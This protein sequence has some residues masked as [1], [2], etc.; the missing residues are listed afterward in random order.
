[1]QAGRAGVVGAAALAAGAAG[2]AALGKRRRQRGWG[3]R[4]RGCL[5]KRLARPGDGYSWEE[6]GRH[7][8]EIKVYVPIGD[9]VNYRDVAFELAPGGRLTVGIQGCTPVIDGEALWGSVDTEDSEW[10]VEQHE[11]QRSIV[12]LLTKRNVRE[13]WE[14]LLKKDGAFIGPQPDLVN[15]SQD[16]AV[17][18]QMD[19]VQYL[20]QQ[21]RLEEAQEVLR[22]MTAGHVEVTDG[23][24]VPVKTVDRGRGWRAA[25]D[26]SA[27]EVLLY[28][29]AFCYSECGPDRFNIMGQQC[30]TKSDDPFF[31]GEVLSLSTAKGGETG[32]LGILQ[33]NT[34][35]CSR[36]PGWTALFAS[37]A[38]FNHSCCPNAFLDSSKSTG[39]VR[40][41][42]QIPVG[43]EVCLS[44]VLVSDTLESRR[45]NLRPFGFECSCDRCREEESSDPKFA[46]PCACGHGK[47]PFRTESKANNMQECHACGQRFNCADAHRV[48]R[49]MEA[50]CDYMESAEAGRAESA[51]LVKMLEPLAAEAHPSIFTG[52][53]DSVATEAL[54]APPRHPVVIR[55][56]DH[57]ARCHY[58]VAA[59]SGP[60]SARDRA[61]S[62]YWECRRRALEGHEANHGSGAAQRDVSYLRRLYQ[63]LVDGLPEEDRETWR[64]KLPALCQV[65]F[66]EAQMPKQLVE[67]LRPFEL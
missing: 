57:L 53:S 41:L 9:E 26:I 61:F 25:K 8:H 52:S 34:F 30:M 40:A 14:H 66:G 38:R 2:A 31:K 24:I 63:L 51:D 55:L 18:E 1:M 27:G 33:N 44:Y 45:A 56:L 20:L 49:E 6:D 19:Y 21:H 39:I 50:M 42:R 22:N 47:S 58:A 67:D 54:Q 13:S 23:R 62:A 3:C 60:G 32:L 15:T 12:V 17:L 4:R 10:M 16:W 36:E 65:Q 59:Q 46:V 11:G 43:E 5:L 64:A 29:T 37:A 28:D 35:E 48:L 7:A